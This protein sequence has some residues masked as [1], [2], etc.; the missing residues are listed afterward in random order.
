MAAGDAM[1]LGMA[2]LGGGGGGT[3]EGGGGPTAFSV[4]GEVGMVRAGFAGRPG[5]YK[6][7]VV[8]GD[9]VERGDGAGLGPGSASRVHHK[10][11]SKLAIATFGSGKTSGQ[12]TG[13]ERG[14]RVEGW[15]ESLLARWHPQELGGCSSPRKPEEQRSVHHTRA[16]ATYYRIVEQVRI[17]T[18]QVLSRRNI[19]HRRRQR[20]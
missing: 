20:V 16:R 8:S 1:S 12:K 2:A 5:D 17:F 15:R 3:R 9:R 19:L 18:I 10:G 4:I 6:A 13:V 7:A 14:G 11:S